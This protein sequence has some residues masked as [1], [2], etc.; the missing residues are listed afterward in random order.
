MTNFEQSI[1]FLYT[2]DLATTSHFYSEVM[3]IP[4]ILDQG[5]CRVW[6][7]TETAF[8]GFCERETAPTEPSTNL[9]F[10]LVTDDVD[11]WHTRLVAAGAD[12]TKPPTLNEK[13][14]IYHI[15]F[16]DPNGY[17]LEIQ[18]FNDPFP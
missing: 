12:I 7:I 1:T 4:L 17:L 5:D 16:R 2:R 6:Q 8:I 11:G 3:Q 9:I 13:Y 15:F 14:N 10:T 18:R